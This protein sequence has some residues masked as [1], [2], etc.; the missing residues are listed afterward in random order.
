MTTTT[1]AFFCGGVVLLILGA[2]VLVRGATRLALVA[3]VSPLVIGLTVVAYGTSAPEA[4]VAIQS[5][6]AQPPKPELVIGN[7]VGS[8]ISNVLLVLGIAAIAAPLL[9][10]R[11]LVRIT[12]PLMIVVSLVV[13]WMARDGEIGQIEGGIL[14]A[15]AVVFTVLSILRSRKTTM[16]ENAADVAN[17]SEHRPMVLQ[18]SANLALVAIGLGMLVLGAQWLVEGAVTVAKLLN[19]S[20]LIIGLTIVAVGTSLPEIAT[21][22]IASFRG[23]RDL[24]VGNVVGSNIFNILLVLGLCA[25]VSREPVVVPLAAIRFDIPIMLAVALACWPIFFT[26]WKISR[27]E[28]LAL[29]T[30]YAGYVVFLFLQATRHD[31]AVGYQTVMVWFVLPLTALVLVMLTLRFSRKKSVEPEKETP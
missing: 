25:A 9:V 31:A 19:V 20:E 4:A 22:L 26:D 3:R 24:A 8:N 23:Q 13:W 17:H 2:D 21:S 12:V 1:I 18:L 7:V 30:Y 10:R 14:L 11:Q 5:M 16:A 6:Y 29:L 15:G 27:W 28:G